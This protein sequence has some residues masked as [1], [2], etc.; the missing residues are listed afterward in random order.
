MRIDLDSHMLATGNSIHQYYID[1][2][3]GLDSSVVDFAAA[4]LCQDKITKK[5]NWYFSSYAS[6]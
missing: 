3:V 1:N 6:L 5:S 2:D 4:T